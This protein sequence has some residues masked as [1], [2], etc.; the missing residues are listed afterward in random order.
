M[1]EKSVLERGP[2]VLGNLWDKVGR[3]GRLEVMRRCVR[4]DQYFTSRYHA[5]AVRIQLREEL[6]I[7]SAGEQL[8][9]N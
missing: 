4:Y 6:E 3:A 2:E 7:S 1:A 8:Y 5:G 9:Y